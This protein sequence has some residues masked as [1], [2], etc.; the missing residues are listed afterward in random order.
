MWER[1][2]DIDPHVQTSRLKVP[3]GWLVRSVV[4]YD[5]AEGTGCA[6]DQTFVSDPNHDWD[7]KQ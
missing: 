4:K 5:T 1:L 6:V 7:L 3:G 2:K